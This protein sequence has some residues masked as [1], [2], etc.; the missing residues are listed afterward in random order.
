MAIGGIENTTGDGDAHRTG[1]APLYRAF[2]SYSHKDS[3]IAAWLTRKLETWRVPNH[4]TAGRGP[5]HPQG[6]R[7]PLQPI[8]RD[9]DELAATHSL[10]ETI[11]TALAQS[12]WL[13][14]LCSPHA[15]A[16]RWVNQE[17][18]T[19]TRVRGPKKILAVIVD[20][21]PM[22]S[23][24]GTGPECF[25]ESLGFTR[26]DGE[27]ALHPSTEPCAADLRDAGDG[28]RLGFLKLAAGMLEVNLDAL[29]RRD[30]IR[31]NRTVTAVTAASLV[32]M[33]LMSGLALAAWNGQREAQHQRAEAIA[34]TQ[35][36]EE[37]IQFMLTE[38]KTELESVGRLDALEIVGK[39]ASQYYQA[40]PLDRHSDDALGRR[41]RVFHFLGEIAGKIGDEEKKNQYFQYAYEATNSLLSRNPQSGDRIFDHAQS[42][43]WKGHALWKTK[44]YENASRYF[45]EYIDLAERLAS[46]ETGTQRSLQELSYAYTNFGILNF[47]NGQIE[48]AIDQYNRSL[49]SFEALANEN[50]DNLQYNI[51]LANAYAW[52]ADA[53]FEIQD[54]EK[55]AQRRTAEI[56]VLKRLFEDH[57]LNTKLQYKALTSSIGMI[58]VRIEQSRYIEEGALLEKNRMI[59]QAL[60]TTDPKNEE[61]LIADLKLQTLQVKV[62]LA[63]EEV[64][65][66]ASI[67]NQTKVLTQ[68]LSEQAHERLESYLQF[69]DEAAL[70]IATLK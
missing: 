59:A 69:Q 34:R 53:Y 22:G 26:T 30:L 19:F 47:S 65:K 14:V 29:V 11:Q 24:T 48:K 39:Q 17:I 67:L 10:S 28:K 13:I 57:P 43:Y 31:R 4:F 41:S 5:L 62:Y 42:S 49:P 20:G 23:I 33:I 35:S 18:E 60:R 6:N 64:S 2:I 27:D 15:R 36:A 68:K 70:Q 52:L 44:N 3:A 66:A 58:R 32:G 45:Q 12:E 56:L 25:P 63:K 38:L 50:P 9:R 7:R 51:D 21:E 37:L 61:F 54:F 46:V 55:A 1:E 16:S 8:F 40:Y